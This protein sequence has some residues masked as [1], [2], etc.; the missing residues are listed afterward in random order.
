MGS[1]ESLGLTRIILRIAEAEPSVSLVAQSFTLLYRRIA[2]G[3]VRKLQSDENYHV[4]RIGNPRYSRLK[5]CATLDARTLHE[6]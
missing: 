4:L 5:I 2:F 1:H 6:S 3:W